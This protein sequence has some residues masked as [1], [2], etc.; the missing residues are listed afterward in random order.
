LVRKEVK[1]DACCVQV[2]RISTHINGLFRKQK[3]EKDTLMKNG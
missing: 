3:L 1:E 2:K